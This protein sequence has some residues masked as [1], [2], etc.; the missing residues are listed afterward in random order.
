MIFPFL[1]DRYCC[2]SAAPLF[3]LRAFQSD[4]ERTK[5]INF[6]VVL[7]PT[8]RQLALTEKDDKTIA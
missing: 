3:V 6:Y 8:N 7:A 5:E 4:G 1:T 2:I